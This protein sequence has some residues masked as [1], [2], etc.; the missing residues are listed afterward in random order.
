MTPSAVHIEAEQ[1]PGFPKRRRRRDLSGFTLIELVLVV[2]ITAVFAA[3]V[4]PRYTQS[5]SRYRA[6]SAARRVVA[7]LEL[8]RTTARN[9]SASQAVRFFLTSSEYELKGM[10]DPIDPTAT[11]R[12]A[13]TDEPYRTVLTTFSLG[14]SDTI[15]FN[16]FGQP[17]RGGTLTLRS[18]DA[19]RTVTIDAQT[20]R[21]TWQ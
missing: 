5:L 3:I 18:G 16:G 6:E 20:G 2:L 11:Y 10:A 4:V 21:A 15:T 17:D 13:L 8:A 9:R 12:V 14:G 1:R 19:V 7:D